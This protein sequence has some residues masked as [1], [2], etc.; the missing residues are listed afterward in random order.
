M[1]KPIIAE[2]FFLFIISY[3][4]ITAIK[5]QYIYINIY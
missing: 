2:L 4:Y 3:K 1:I 5:F